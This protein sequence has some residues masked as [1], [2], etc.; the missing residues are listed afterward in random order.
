MLTEICGY[1]KNWF[2]MEQCYGKFVISDGAITYADGME[3]PLQNG[4]YFCVIG[5]IFNDGV[6]IFVSSSNGALAEQSALALPLKDEEFT[7]CV[8]CMAVPQALINVALE[9]HRWNEK[10]GGADSP[11]KSPFNSESFGGYSCSKGSGSNTDAS[12]GSWQGA[13]AASLSR[14]RKL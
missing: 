8:K 6:H 11:A 2:V 7:G 5:S 10:Y 9:I 4:Q 13:F 14:Y 3:L 12:A 1:L